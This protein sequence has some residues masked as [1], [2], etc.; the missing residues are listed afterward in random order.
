MSV[1]VERKQNGSSNTARP[2]GI[3]PSSVGSVTLGNGRLVR[4]PQSKSKS[5]AAGGLLPAAPSGKSGADGGAKKMNK[6][7][8]QKVDGGVCDLL[9]TVPQVVLYQYEA[10]SNTWVRTTCACV[11]DTISRVVSVQFV[12]VHTEHIF[13]KC[14][15]VHVVHVHVCVYMCEFCRNGHVLRE[16]CLSTAGTQYCVCVCV[17]SV[18]M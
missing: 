9:S 18:Y 15:C 4:E 5:S 16:L 12:L 11:Y 17:W 1:L 6:M 8:V 10:D 14:A 7:A 2:H 3:T 13:Y